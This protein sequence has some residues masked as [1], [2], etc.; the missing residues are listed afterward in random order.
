[1]HIYIY[2]YYFFCL[3]SVFYT[4]QEI[5]RGESRETWLL[6]NDLVQDNRGVRAEKKQVQEMTR[7]K[8]LKDFAV[9]ISPARAIYSSCI[10]IEKVWM[11]DYQDFIWRN[12][13]RDFAVQ[14]KQFSQLAMQNQSMI[15]FLLSF[16]WTNEHLEL[17]GQTMQSVLAKGNYKQI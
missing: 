5:Q 10:L 17:H 6:H 2:A 11:I 15:S 12:Y 4:K 13:W 1:M 7:N 16:E 14:N 9:L 3:F 8:Y